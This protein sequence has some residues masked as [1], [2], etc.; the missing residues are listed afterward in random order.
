MGWVDKWEC[1]ECDSTRVQDGGGCV[2]SH[3]KFSE[4]SKALECNL[5]LWMK[6]KSWFFLF[7]SLPILM[8]Q[9][10][11]TFLLCSRLVL[12]L[13]NNSI[14]RL[15][16]KMCGGKTWTGTRISSQGEG[17]V[18]LDKK[19]CTKILYKRI[20]ILEFSKIKSFKLNPLWV[21]CTHCMSHFY[22]HIRG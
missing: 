22:M 10:L 21:C 6:L 4:L 18:F 12:V 20:F 14:E 5:S 13:H 19:M 2:V 8:E 7:C 15:L 3:W 1:T 11:L 9:Q 17:S 16:D